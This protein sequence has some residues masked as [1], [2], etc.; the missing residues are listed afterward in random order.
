MVSDLI[1]PV[2]AQW[3]VDVV[4]ALFNP[5]DVEEI[6]KIPICSGMEDCVAWFFDKKGMF[7]V[8]SAYRLGVN[9]R[10]KKRNKDTSTSKTPV[11]SPR[12]DKIWYL[13]L[14]G[15]VRVFLW[16]LAHN[17]LPL[18]LNVKR[19]KSGVGHNLPYVQSFR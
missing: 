9:L 13:K 3:E 18:R 15:K 1:D 8:K 16:R 6:L 19:K 10:E 17:S 11:T 7:S 2:T 4:Q 12:W 14:P 5:R